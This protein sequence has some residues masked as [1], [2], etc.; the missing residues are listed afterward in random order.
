MY[1]DSADGVKHMWLLPSIMGGQAV[2][3]H[4]LKGC[5]AGP[6]FAES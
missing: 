1:N 6:I 4:S 2:C 3:A 5:L